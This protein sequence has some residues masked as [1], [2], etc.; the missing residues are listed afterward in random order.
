MDIFLILKDFFLDSIQKKNNKL[1]IFFL[2]IG[3][4]I[5][6]LIKLSPSMFPLLL[7]DS[8]DYLSISNSSTRTSIYP[9]IN[10]LTNYLNID[11][12]EL[13]VILLSFSLSSLI[14]S[15]TYRTKS[16]IVFLLSL[17]LLCSNYYYT[18]FSKTILTES[19]FF[20]FINFV[21]TILIGVSKQTKKTLLLLG[22][23]SGLIITIKPIG[24]VIVTPIILYLILLNR[25]FIKQFI[26]ITSTLTIIFCESLIFYSYHEQRSS[27]LPETMSGKIYM[28]S[29]YKSFDYKVFPNRFHEL[30][31]EIEKKSEKINRFLKSVNNPLLK[32]DLTADYEV[33]FQTQTFNIIKMQDSILF[34]EFKDDKKNFYICLKNNIL[35]YLS[36]SFSHYLGQWLTGPKFIF[37]DDLVKIGEKNIPFYEN[38]IL[39]SSEFDKPS[40]IILYISLFFFLSL[41]LIFTLISFISI[42]DVFKRRKVDLV[43]LLVATAQL[44]LVTT[45]LV[46]ISTIRYL[47]PIYPVVILTI[48]LFLFNKINSIFISSNFSNIKK[49]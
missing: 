3:F 36:L 26:L 1:F 40:K 6:L 34:Q 12:I 38:L 23:L 32:I 4:G 45:S 41:F 20:S 16:L 31:K 37:W 27:I 18:S 15:I 33:V 11:I 10:Q 39:S 46:N 2:I 42:L 25:N 7:P 48:I 13:Q 47:M 43:A 19:F 5:F 17:M 29:G 30:V 24:I 8:E 28:L 49:D 44:Y 9:G 21:M 22:T 14:I 35:N